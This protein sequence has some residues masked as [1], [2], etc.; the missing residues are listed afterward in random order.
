MIYKMSFE[1]TH[2]VT[3]AAK[4]RLEGTQKTGGSESMSKLEGDIKS[5]LL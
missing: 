2:L 1:D 4:T 5:L 3:A